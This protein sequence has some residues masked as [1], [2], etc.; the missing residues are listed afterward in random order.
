ME[1]ADKKVEEIFKNGVDYLEDGQLE[2]AIKA[3]EEVISLDDNDA[4]AHFNL[5]L[6]CMRMVRKDIDREELYEE[7]TDE[8]AWILRAISEFN[9]VLEIEPDNMEAKKNIEALNKLL[10]MGV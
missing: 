9:K 10:G 7:R 4:A 2:D 3:F 6:V 1:N 8:E 5:G